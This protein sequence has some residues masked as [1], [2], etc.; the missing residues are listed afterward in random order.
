[1]LKLFQ[2]LKSHNMQ[3]TNRNYQ[4]KTKKI[5]EII[6]KFG[7]KHSEIERI[8]L[9]AIPGDINGYVFFAPGR[10]SRKFEDEVS[11][12]SL[13]IMQEYQENVMMIVWPSLDYRVERIIYRKK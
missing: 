6:K 13:R 5:E 8:G 12:L 10:Y 7:R 3:G 9:S 11:E 2:N 4:A 1:L